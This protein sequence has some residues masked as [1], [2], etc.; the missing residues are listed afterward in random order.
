MQVEACLKLVR[1]Y[2]AIYKKCPLTHLMLKI[3]VFNTEPAHKLRTIHQ[4]YMMQKAHDD[5]NILSLVYNPL[6]KASV[7][8]PIRLNLELNSSRNVREVAETD[9]AEVSCASGSNLV[10]EI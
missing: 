1:M 2:T 3:T 10:M 6:L 4:R 8:R 9:E 5:S 7:L